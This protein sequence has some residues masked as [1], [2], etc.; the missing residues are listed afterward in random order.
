MMLVFGLGEAAAQGA[1]QVYVVDVAPENRRGT[2]MGTW[3]LFNA[4]GGI[5][6]P[7][8]IGLVADATGFGPA[9]MFVGGCLVL[10][11]VV[12]GVFGPE[13]GQHKGVVARSNP[14][15]AGAPPAP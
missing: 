3:N 2:F 10:S 15:S 6:A 12:M 5:S 7:V 1:A 4:V 8:T 14:T 11:A 9:F 13:F